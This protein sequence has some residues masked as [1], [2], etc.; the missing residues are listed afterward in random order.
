G[1]VGYGWSLSI[2][3]IER[4]NKIG[5]Q[6]LYGNTPYFT[7][8]V[9]GELV[10]AP[11]TTSAVSNGDV[12]PTILDTTPFVIDSSSNTA[13]G[14]GTSVS[15]SSTVPA[16]GSNKALVV[17]I[18]GVQPIACNLT[19][20]QNGSSVPMTYLYTASTAKQSYIWYGTLAAPTSGTLSA[21]WDCG[22]L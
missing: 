15:F 10:L 14:S 11:T 9:D 8:S 17:L 13:H 22:S 19:V 2:P 3:Y 5:T 7:S 6:D 1:I 16:S 12:T 4:L 21:S 18:E 20:T